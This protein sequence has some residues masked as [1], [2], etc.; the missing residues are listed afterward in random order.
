M[1]NSANEKK[2]KICPN[3]DNGAEVRITGRVIDGG[4]NEQARMAPLMVCCLTWRRHH[5]VGTTPRGTALVWGLV[6][7]G[8]STP[9]LCMA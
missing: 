7:W 4:C 2:E 3:L 8:D 9:Q 6:P 1:L 5:T